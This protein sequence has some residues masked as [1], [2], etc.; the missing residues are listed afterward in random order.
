MHLALQLHAGH[1]QLLE[2]ELRGPL[3]AEQRDS[4]VRIRRSARALMAKKDY[5][6]AQLQIKTLLQAK[7][8]SAEGRFLLG[9]V[10]LE[11]GDAAGAE[12]ELRRA[13]ELGQSEVTVLPLLSGAM[14]GL[15]KGALLLQQFGKEG[16]SIRVVFLDASTDAL[17]RRFSE[18]RRP[19]P[20]SQA[21]P[22]RGSRAGHHR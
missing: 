10:M 21:R 11:S 15:G 13:L 17:V 7:P 4:I 2:A 19:H 9:Q 16:V 6:A 5:N 12:A 3:S 22:S 20:L 18:T 8:D 14:V 1:A